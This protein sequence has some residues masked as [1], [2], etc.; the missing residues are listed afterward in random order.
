MSKILYIGEDT[1]SYH[2]FFNGAS[3]A[4]TV[5]FFNLTDF[6]NLS[7]SDHEVEQISSAEHIIFSRDIDWKTLKI[8]DRIAKKN[9]PYSYYADDNYFILNRIVP[10][11]K[12]NTFL[13]SADALISTTNAMNGF[14]TSIATDN[15]KLIQL[16]LDVHI[17]ERSNP[18]KTLSKQVLNIGFLGTGKNWLYQDVLKDLSDNLLDYELNI[19]APL[20]LCK[21]LRK[22][23]IA[24]SITLIEFKFIKNYSQ[25]IDTIK[26]FDLDFI[27]QPA[28]LTDQN[29]HF[30]N[31][32]S[33]L[34]PYHCNCLTLF[35]DSPPYNSIQQEGLE[36]LLTKNNAFSEKINAL[37]S[38]NDKRIA[39]TDALFSFVE[40]NFSANNN[41]QKL[42][43]SLRFKEKGA[44][45]FS[46]E[47][48]QLRF[49]KIEKTYNK[50][51]RSIYR[52]L[53]AS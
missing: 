48:K 49:T 26:T 6:K 40:N 51:K 7:L 41:I 2:L 27:L 20:S 13:S 35:C 24:D 15:N 10:S 3:S 34:L 9:I 11:N 36:E 12:V 47:L 39:L 14:F 37:I 5:S 4:N 53:I 16:N 21:L 25:F 17:P 46:Q 44:D 31:L 30:K 45:R 1:A 19:H 50:Y 18:K 52:K 8:A 33:L 23:P 29:Y 32:N 38:N 28:D 42:K 43:E 22:Q